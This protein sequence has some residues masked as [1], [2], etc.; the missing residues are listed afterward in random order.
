MADGAAAGMA[1][2]AADG[3]AAG[4]ADGPRGAVRSVNVGRPRRVDWLGRR[5][6]SAI[7]KEPVDG[8]VRVDGVNLDGD[9]QADRRV[10]GGPD[11]A[12]YAYAVEDYDWWAASTGP[13]AP[14]TFGDNLTTVGLDLTGSHIGDRWRVGTAVLEVAQPREP[15]FKLGMRMGDEHFPGRFA[16][17][18]RPGAYLRIVEPGV[19][20]AG[21]AIVIEPAARPAVRIGDLAKGDLD[22]AALRRIADDERVPHGWRRAAQ[23]ALGRVTT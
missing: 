2:G 22:E 6:Q 16:A 8:P 4:A 12:V 10:H 19:I 5:V 3:A 1:E 17:A 23:R 15:C 9:D 7:W 18:G 11:K 14:G 13:L 21:D 20:G